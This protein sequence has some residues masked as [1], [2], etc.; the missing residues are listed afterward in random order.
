MHNE[1]LL[2]SLGLLW[3][4]SRLVPGV[5]RLWGTPLML[6]C[7]QVGALVLAT[8]MLAQP[9]LFPPPYPT[10][11]LRPGAMGFAMPPLLALWAGLLLARRWEWM[12]LT[13]FCLVAL[14]A[15]PMVIGPEWVVPISEAWLWAATGSVSGLS[16]ALFGSIVLLA[17]SAALLLPETAL[18]RVWSRI[19]AALG[20]SLLWIALP[21]QYLALPGGSTGQLLLSAATLTLA[22]FLLATVAIRAPERPLLLPAALDQWRQPLLQVLPVS[23]L[24]AVYFIVKLETIAWSA[25]DENIYFLAAQWV[26]SGRVPYRDFFFSHPPL[27]LL[28][29]ALLLK[30]FGEAPYLLK[31]IP[32]LFS[33]GSGVLVYLAML[34]RGTTLAALLASGAFFFALEQL[35]ASTN[36]TGI[37]ITTFFVVLTAWALLS[38][39]AWTAAA[40]GCA[41]LMTGAYST[42]PV[43]ALL[44]P[45]FLLGGHR[46]GLRFLG[47]LLGGYL[48]LTG[49][50][51]AAFG[52]AYF[53]Q[54]FEYHFLKPAGQAVGY[55]APGGVDLLAL[56]LLGAAAALLSWVV[57]RYRQKVDGSRRAVMIAQ[58]VVLGLVVAGIVLG[59]TQVHV[60]EEAA[61]GATPNS[62]YGGAALLWADLWVFA[63]DDEFLRFAYFHSHL[64]LAPVLLGLLSLLEPLRRRVTAGAHTPVNPAGWLGV[65]MMAS[66]LVQLSLVKET[67]TFYY[68]LAIP[69]G[70]MALGA[71]WELAFRWV[72]LTAL[73]FRRRLV[74]GAV[75]LLMLVGLAAYQPLSLAVGAERWP[76]EKA[77][78]YSLVC[79]PWREGASGPFS[80]LVRQWL[81]TPCRTRGSAETGLL[82][83]LWKKK[84][85]LSRAEELAT[86]IRTHS[87]PGDT[88]LGASVVAP[89]LALLSGRDLAAGYLDTNAKRFKTGMVQDATL[90]TQLCQTHPT[91]TPQ[92]CLQQAAW[93]EMWE[94]ACRTPLRFIVAAP[95]SAFQVSELSRNPLIRK[96]FRFVAVFNDDQ[97]NLDGTYPIVLYQ[98]IQDK[99]DAAGRYCGFD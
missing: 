20:L 3:G 42:V 22:A 79:Y 11:F 51:Y 88:I 30:V 85:Y 12:R 36:L 75:A 80:P 4:L 34:R 33:V 82:H 56:L 21:T 13:G 48:L 73:T 65:L 93:R 74:A 78:R 5:R 59:Y 98:R 94:R 14:V 62:A 2:P 49:T 16:A 72:P 41:A 54:V 55:M 69:G 39:R 50:C 95:K 90:A 87:A 19:L 43:L 18:E 1:V 29:P 28:V 53:E 66:A 7:W 84:G 6:L 31:L 25:T 64:L 10:Q 89:L 67:Y 77:A 40:A 44:L 63:G 38:Q 47:G 24:V 37:N 58:F 8:W 97:W 32:V 27:H 70:A 83:Y 96:Y 52:S 68:L 99:P 17:S 45:A 60:A 91:W 81:Y 23:A 86:Y 61:E 35:Q 15:V 71:A 92:Q 26:A 9:L 76:E 57:W 46:L